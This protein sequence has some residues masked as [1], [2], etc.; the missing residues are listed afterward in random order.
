MGRYDNSGY[1]VDYLDSFKL[2]NRYNEPCKIIR[3]RNDGLVEVEVSY[4]IVKRIIVPN[5]CIRV[6]K[7]NRKCTVTRIHREDSPPE[8]ETDLTESQALNR[9][10]D[11]TRQDVLELD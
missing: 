3:W 6:T 11:I 1:T 4:P 10:A 7:Y 9:L 8:C 2:R 5:N